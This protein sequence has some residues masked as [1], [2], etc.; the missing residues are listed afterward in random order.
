MALIEAMIE[1]QEL[2][3]IHLVHEDMR[4][5][6]TVGD[7]IKLVRSKLGGSSEID[8]SDPSLLAM[9]EIALNHEGPFRD[10]A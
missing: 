3:G 8:F 4:E 5:L 2:Y 9:Y 6:Q 10:A 1:L 7:L